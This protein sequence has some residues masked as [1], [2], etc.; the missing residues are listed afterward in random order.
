ME[1][2]SDDIEEYAASYPDKPRSLLA[3]GS[4]VVRVSEFDEETGVWRSRIKMSGRK[5]D[6]EAKG[7]FLQQYLK[8]GRMTES[9]AAA[10][11]STQTVRKAME[12]DED[13]AEAMLEAD[14][15][16]HDKLIDHHQNLVFEGTEKINYD[17]MGNI[18][19]RE[20]IYPI[21]LI[22]LELKK[23]DKG[24][25]EKQELQI[26]HT[27]GVLVAPAEL[28]SIADW[29]KRFAIAKDI[30]PKDEVTLGL[31]ADDPVSVIP[32]DKA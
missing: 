11:V 14:G 29:E 22:E 23:H 16:Y 30:T 31:T 5:F 21:R 8:W 32:D 7:V 28:K 20:R 12:D 13:F 10:G 25:R 2:F 26:A 1:D 15:A 6:E 17:R 4:K 27:G 18:V 19:S 3:K 24:Y 9:A